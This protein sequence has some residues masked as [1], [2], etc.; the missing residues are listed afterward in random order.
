MVAH[1]LRVAPRQKGHRAR[2]FTFK[3]D[4]CVLRTR[5]VIPRRL[6]KVGSLSRLGSNLHALNSGSTRRSALK[7]PDFHTIGPCPDQLCWLQNQ[8]QLKPSQ[9][10]S[11][12]WKQANLTC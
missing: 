8:N 1:T 11:W 6:Q 9:S 7:S 12:C 3:A 5:D 10:A 4:S 2:S